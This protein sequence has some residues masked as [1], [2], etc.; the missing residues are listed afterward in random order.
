M[1]GWPARFGLFLA[2]E[3][4]SLDAVKAYCTDRSP[5]AFNAAGRIVCRPKR[6]WCR[7]W[8]YLSLCI[9]RLADKCNARHS[10]LIKVSAR[11]GKRK[12]TAG[13][14]V[15]IIDDH[16]AVLEG[17]RSMIRLCVENLLVVATF[18]SYDEAM[19]KITILQPDLVLA[20]YRVPGMPLEKFLQA[21]RQVN[22]A[23]AVLVVSASSNRD[24]VVA[25]LRGGAS[26]FVS[27]YVSMPEL[28][29][30]INAVL[31]GDAWATGD[32]IDRL[33]HPGQEPSAGNRDSGGPH[34]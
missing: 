31:R 23:L 20:D 17:L 19:T 30:A 15:M 1:E 32:V 28:R 8:H 14:P 22:P 10:W 11:N 27:K 25:A 26:G 2:E 4:S 12:A 21:A 3:S 33:L 24:D 16:P 18:G 6:G 7:N 13:S 5:S 34:G 29:D 9:A